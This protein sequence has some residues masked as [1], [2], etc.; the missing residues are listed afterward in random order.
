[1]K[2]RLAA[3]IRFML[4]HKSSCILIDQEELYL[5]TDFG[6]AKIRSHAEDYKLQRYCCYLSGMDLSNTRADKKDFMFEV[7]GV[8]RWL[9]FERSEADRFGKIILMEEKCTD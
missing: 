2:Q 6:F 7:D 5:E 4:K 1:M 9:S 8:N 3:L